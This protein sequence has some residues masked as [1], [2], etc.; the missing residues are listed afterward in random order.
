MVG[1]EIRDSGKEPA[2]KIATALEK[3]PSVFNSMP[4]PP[5]CDSAQLDSKDWVCMIN[6]I[7]DGKARIKRRSKKGDVMKRMMAGVLLVGLG[8]GTMFADNGY[9]R[10]RQDIRHDEARIARDRN[11]LRRDLYYGNYAG[12]H[13]EQRELRRDCRDLS[14]DRLDLY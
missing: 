2:T 14:R 12:A 5:P 9:E 4:A 3:F 10:D 7:P 1:T 11:D 6:A 8:A 13:H